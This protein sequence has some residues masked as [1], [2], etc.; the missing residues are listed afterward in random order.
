[1]GGCDMTMGERA[2][3]L[4]AESWQMPGR[5][6]PNRGSQEAARDARVSELMCWGFVTIAMADMY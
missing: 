1:M 4:Q 2:V 5:R 3:S 6:E